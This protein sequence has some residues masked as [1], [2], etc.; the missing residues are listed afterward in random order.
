M[1][2]FAALCVA[3]ACQPLGGLPRPPERFIPVQ[4]AWA[5]SEPS[6]ND[7][8]RHHVAAAVNEICVPRALLSDKK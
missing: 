7:Q 8:A 2:P 4:R 3:L 5:I 1:R 6:L